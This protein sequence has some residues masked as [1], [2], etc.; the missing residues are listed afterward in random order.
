MTRRSQICTRTHPLAGC[1]AGLV[2][3]TLKPVQCASALPAIRWRAWAVL[4]AGELS[5]GLAWAL[6]VGM[7]AAG[8]AIVNANFG[9]LILQLYS[10]GLF[11]GTIYR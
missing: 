10:F 5:T 2:V 9:R 4:P 6:V 3:S 7:G 11:L 8:V 1:R